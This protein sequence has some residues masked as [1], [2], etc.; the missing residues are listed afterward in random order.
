MVVA[1]I[2]SMNCAMQRLP[3]DVHVGE[4]HDGE[5]VER[6]RQPRQRHLDLAH[7]HA[8]RALRAAPARPAPADTA[9]ARRAERA[10]QK[11]PPLGI[12]RAAAG[13]HDEAHHV[14]AEDTTV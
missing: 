7:A 2:S 5:A 11:Q 10:P 3:A 4:L 8:P 13:V 6:L 14:G 12:A 1:T 9:A